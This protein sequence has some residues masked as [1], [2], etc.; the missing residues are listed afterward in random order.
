[1]AI[2][3]LTR[4]LGWNLVLTLNHDTIL[5]RAFA[6]EGLSPKIF[7]VSRDA[8]VPDAATVGRDPLSIV[9]LHGSAYGIRVGEPT[10]YALD[11]V[12]R[13]RILTYAPRSAVILVIGFSGYERRMMSVIESFAD[14]QHPIVWM[15]WEPEE[16][17][18]E[19]AKRLKNR[20]PGN[21][22]TFRLR[23]AGSFLLGLLQRAT[24]SLPHTRGRYRALPKR[25]FSPIESPSANLREH[26]RKVGAKTLPVRLFCATSIS[27]R[28][29]PSEYPFLGGDR[30]RVGRR[31]ESVDDNGRIC[32]LTERLS[33]DLD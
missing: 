13:T 26:E 15:H 3:L 1:M 29:E 20:F 19:P 18:P 10:N 23:D 17:L 9:K 11:D 14:N 25:V 28:E 31:V 5:E 33:C 21:F 6:Q 24:R 16:E 32:S 30:A 22:L 8:D 4:H 7:D 27:K 2:A 12:T